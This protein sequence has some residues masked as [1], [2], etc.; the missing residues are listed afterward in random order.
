MYENV[1]VILKPRD[2]IIIQFRK[3]RIILNS[4]IE[5]AYEINI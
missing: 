3:V 5:K 4:K 2:R 1:L